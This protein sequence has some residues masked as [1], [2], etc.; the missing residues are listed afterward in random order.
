MSS[1]ITEKVD[2]FGSRSRFWTGPRSGGSPVTDLGEKNSSLGKATLD[3]F[4]DY[5]ISEK[6]RGDAAQ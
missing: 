2:E 3:N 6:E 1:G 4:S 5:K